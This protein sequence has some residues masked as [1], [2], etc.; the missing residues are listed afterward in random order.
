MYMVWVFDE[1]LYDDV[2]IFEGSYEQCQEVV[3]EGRAIG[4]DPYIVASEDY[5]ED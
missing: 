1:D 2:L 4:E 5:Y 3:A